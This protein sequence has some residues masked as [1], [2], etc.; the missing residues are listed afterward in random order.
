MDVLLY[1]ILSSNHTDQLKK[2]LMQKIADKGAFPQNI[3]TVISVFELTVNW[4]LDSD[5]DLASTEGLS[6]LKSW[7][8]HNLSTFE[9]FFN[10]EYLVSL[11]S[12]KC[13]R[14]FN[15]PILIKNCLLLLNGS[16]TFYSHLKCIQAMAINYIQE[17]PS[18]R[19]IVN[20]INLLKDYK[21]CIPQGDFTSKFCVSVIHGVALTSRPEGKFTVME[22]INGSENIFKFIN[23]LWQQTD[24]GII[25]ESL[26]A[27][28]A[29]ISNPEIEMSFCLGAVVQHI[30]KEM[31]LIVVKY[32]VF[33]SKVDDDSMTRAL[34]RIIEWIQWPTAINVDTWIIGFLQS[35]AA[36]KRFTILISVTEKNIEQ[37]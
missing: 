22:Y 19:C 18:M 8:K 35:L 4:Y 3:K 12:R 30:P 24:S 14:E 23:A 25:L 28:F 36:E 6:I 29:A 5:S 21:E 15:V 33:E 17:H 9:E 16:S 7:A 2:Q 37:V 31:I 34:N 32:A 26:K 13:L 1:G 10:R 11:L 27:I 20:F